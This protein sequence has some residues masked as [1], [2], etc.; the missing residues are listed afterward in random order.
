[1]FLEWLDDQREWQTYPEPYAS[2]INSA[3]LQGETSVDIDIH[4]TGTIYHIDFEIMQQKNIGTDRSRQIKQQ[5]TL[6]DAAVAGQP[7]DPDHLCPICF[8]SRNL[9]A[10]ILPCRH[11]VCMGCAR[12]LQS[13][14]GKCWCRGQIKYVHVLSGEF[15]PIFADR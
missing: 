6:T 15:R 13:T 11:V 10:M 5:I 12:K 14:S 7:E 4:F 8:E 2:E 1:M 9:V 3:F